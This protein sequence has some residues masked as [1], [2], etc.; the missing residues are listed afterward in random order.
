M[1]ALVGVVC[2]VAIGVMCATWMDSCA[3]SID[4]D[5]ITAE[6]VSAILGDVASAA[7]TLYRLHP[8]IG[9]NAADDSLAV[10]IELLQEPSS[11]A[12][13]RAVTDSVCQLILD[14]LMAQGH[15]PREDW[16]YVA[17]HA[18]RPTSRLSPTGAKQIRKMGDSRYDCSNDRIEFEA[19]A[20]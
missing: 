2:L 4:R 15:H 14:G 9:A 3:R 7:P 6:Q 18:Y 8:S 19:P 10:S 16:I 1:N 12:D 11:Y 20:P 13:V 17:V 5:P